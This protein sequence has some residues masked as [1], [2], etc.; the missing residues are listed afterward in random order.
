MSP[1]QLMGK[2]PTPHSDIYALGVILFELITGRHPHIAENAQPTEA[3]LGFAI[4]SSAPATLDS[5]DPSIPRYIVELVECA[6]SKDPEKRFASMAQFATAMREC[7]ARYVREFPQLAELRELW[8]PAPSASVVIRS[9]P[10]QD[11]EQIATAVVAVVPPQSLRPTVRLHSAANEPQ[12]E[13]PARASAP[14]PRM[15]LASTPAP[16]VGGIVVAPCSPSNHGA[17][18]ALTLEFSLRRVVSIGTAIGL[19]VGMG[20]SVVRLRTISAPPT[21]ISTDTETYAPPTKE[22][23]AVATSGVP[24]ADVAQT[25]STTAPSRTSPVLSSA[26]KPAASRL[27]AGTLPKSRHSTQ[28]DKKIADRVNWYEDEPGPAKDRGPKSG[29]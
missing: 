6:L 20:F 2:K 24:A 16:V 26:P 10:P 13:G 3:E 22:A 8:V 21:T 11:Q 27:P 12:P 4:V 7:H 17:Q 5:V 18:P 1:Y 28:T 19:T 14:P 15:S 9:A 29:L 25:S 23:V